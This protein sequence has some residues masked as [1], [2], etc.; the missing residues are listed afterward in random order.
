MVI[1]YPGVWVLHHVYLFKAVYFNNFIYTELPAPPTPFP[2]AHTVSIGCDTASKSLLNVEQ[3]DP[4]T[5]IRS[6]GGGGGGEGGG[7]AWKQTICKARKSGRLGSRRDWVL[8]IWN[9][10][11]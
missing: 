4:L 2:E 1:H 11:G 6:G 7:Q 8:A 9:E 10:P 5:K 3:N